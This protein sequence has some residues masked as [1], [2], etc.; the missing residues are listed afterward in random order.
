M[1]SSLINRFL[2]LLQAAFTEEYKLIQDAF[3]WFLDKY[4][5]LNK[6]DR[7]SSKEEMTKQWNLA[8][9]FE[10]LVAQLTKGLIF[11][12]YAGAP[13]LQEMVRQNCPTKVV[14]SLQNSLSGASMPNEIH[15]E[16]GRSDG[17]WDEC[18]PRGGRR[19]V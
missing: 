7:S 14:P 4:A 1:N 3:Q 15:H 16:D 10:T 11:A 12:Q 6:V 18:N 9:G 19:R 8:D 2:T 13:I 17:I 5:D